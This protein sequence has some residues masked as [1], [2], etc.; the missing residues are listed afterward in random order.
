M[1]TKLLETQ[2]FDTHIAKMKQEGTVEDQT[3]TKSIMNDLTRHLRNGT[4]TPFRLYA[5]ETLATIMKD[6]DDEIKYGFSKHIPACEGKLL[7][8]PGTTY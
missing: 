2:R 5:D 1:L 4:L 3:H 7:E 8:F 6:L